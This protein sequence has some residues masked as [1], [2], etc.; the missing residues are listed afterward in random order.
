MDFYWTKNIELVDEISKIYKSGGLT[1]VLGAGVSKGCGL[2]SWPELVKDLHTEVCRKNYNTAD[3]LYGS[4]ENPKG[5]GGLQTARNGLEAKTLNNLPL[6]IQ[7]R[8]C[9]SKL[10]KNYTKTLQKTLYKNNFTISK[11]VDSIIKLQSL[12]AICTYNYDDIIETSGKKGQFRSIPKSEISYKSGIPVYHVHGMLP[13]DISKRPKGDIIFSEDEYHEL[14]LNFGHWSNIIQLSLFIESEIVLFIGLSFDDPNLRRLLDGAKS[15][16]KGLKLYNI[17]KL[18]FER[19]LNHSTK[20][21]LD[22]NEVE[23]SVYDQVYKNIGVENI[24][25]DEYDPDISILLEAFVAKDSIESYTDSTRKNLKEKLKAIGITT[26]ICHL[27]GCNDRC[28]KGSQFCILHTLGDK[29]R[30][31]PFAPMPKTSKDIC[32]VKGCDKITSGVSNTCRYH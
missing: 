10:G 28:V 6:P 3:G 1:L 13:S 23:V 2:P 27:H 25:V 19:Y 4:F 20:T 29:D 15:A 17:C 32:S 11:T 26:E 5:W 31:M 12:K 24:W 21:P 9:K 7:S 14:Y 16:K 8:F 22:P 18:P 30:Y